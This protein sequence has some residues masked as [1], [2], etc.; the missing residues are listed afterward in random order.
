MVHPEQAKEALEMCR[1]A[2][3]NISIDDFGTGY[4]SLSYLHHFPI[5]TLKIDQAF[6][7]QMTEDAKVKALVK[8]IIQLGKSMELKIIA[9]GAESLEEAHTLKAL[10]CD[11]VQGYYFAKP[12]AEDDV[13]ELIRNTKSFD[14]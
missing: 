13:I 6:V 2:G 5:D 12:M 9:E 3:M 11:M 1:K 14:I 8:T 4:S 7:R 10:G